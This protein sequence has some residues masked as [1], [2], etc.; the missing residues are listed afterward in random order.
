MCTYLAGL[1][2]FFSCFIVLHRSYVFTVGLN[3]FDLVE[4]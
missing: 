3:G 2:G 1:N 4:K